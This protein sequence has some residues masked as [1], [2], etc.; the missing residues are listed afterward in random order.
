MAKLNAKQLKKAHQEL[1]DDARQR[2]AD[3]GVLQFRAGPET[4]LAVMDAAEKNNVPV[5]SLLR[6][7]VQ[8]KLALENAYKRAPDLLERISVLEEAVDYLQKKV[9]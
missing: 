3:R 7:W 4:I 6:Q 9:K 5:G 1:K 8:E 2:V